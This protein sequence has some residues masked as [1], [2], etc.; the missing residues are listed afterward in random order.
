M[1]W[2][3]KARKRLA[4]GQ[5]RDVPQGLWTKCEGCGEVI[6]TRQLEENAHI[7]PEC[8]RHF[9]IGIEP[10]LTIL[11]DR[12]FEEEYDARL[13][14][15]DPLGFTDSKRYTDR[16]RQAHEKTGLE[17]AVRT[18]RV[19]IEGRDVV[20]ALMDFSFLGGSMGSAVGEK[21]ARATQRATTERLPLIILSA[22]G[23]A[24]MQEGILSLMQM[25]KT[26]GRLARHREAGLPFLSILTHPTT[27]G[28]TASFAMLGDVIVAEPGA[29]IG[30]AGPRVIRETI[31][32]ELPED[33]QTSEFLLEHGF[34]DVIASR[35]RLRETVALL[36]SHLLD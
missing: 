36:L 19:R 11:T 29:L 26:S 17:E 34:V 10:Y 27:G 12:G 2:F 35:D 1:G 8:G 7:C 32:Q 31:G 16:L 21:I 23:G 33:F 24:R 9:R 25:A 20:V 6:Y 22:S 15:I 5:K 14:S 13:R 18:G 4:A 28:V 30:F 3:R